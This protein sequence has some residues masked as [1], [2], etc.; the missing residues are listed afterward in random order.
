[1]KKYESPT[2]VTRG[3]IRKVTQGA[4]QDFGVDGT[5]PFDLQW[6]APAS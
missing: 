5:F 6:G 2:I 3:D 1:M 4:T